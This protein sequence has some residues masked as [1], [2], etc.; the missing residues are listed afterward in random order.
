M[1][2][3]IPALVLFLISLYSCSTDMYRVD[4][5][6]SEGFEPQIAVTAVLNPDSAINL[7]C[8][9]TVV[10]YSN[11]QTNSPVINRAMLYDITKNNVY[12]LT[13][14]RKDQS[15]LLS[16][17]DLKPMQGGV[18]KVVLETSNPTA[19]IVIT[20]TVPLLKPIITDV[21][22]SSIQNTIDFS[23][24]VHFIPVVSESTVYY[25]LA[26]FRQNKISLSPNPPEPF[27]QNTLKTS[28]RI[29]TQE[30]YYPSLL[31]LEAENPQSLL[32][33]TNKNNTINTINFEY[34]AGSI[35]YW[36][37]I[38]SID[39]N[40]RIELRVVSYNYFRYKTSL[41]KQKYAAEGDLLY[42]M[43]APVK[44]YSNVMGGVGVLGSYCKADTTVFVEGKTY[45]N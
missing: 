6:L 30:D 19:S 14:R 21:K 27:W 40:L 17:N 4:I 45:R 23:G 25:E 7:S 29:V 43:P 22:V 13:K 8:M 37:H 24:T 35:D 26:I 32:F 5:D 33:R 15:I 9:S 36:G 1:H 31:L 18:Y 28:D 42:G 34:S 39:N 41:Y 16:L 10:A 44:V 12:E 2:I 38:S 20:D 3:K 11:K